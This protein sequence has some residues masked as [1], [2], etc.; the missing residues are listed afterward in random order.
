MHMDS[1]II[2]NKDNQKHKYTGDV[3]FVIQWHQLVMNFD[4]IIWVKLLTAD[5]LCLYLYRLNRFRSPVDINIWVNSE[6]ADALAVS[7]I[8]S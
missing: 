1:I 8:M 3:F 7:I 4:L 2:L 5:A 6:A